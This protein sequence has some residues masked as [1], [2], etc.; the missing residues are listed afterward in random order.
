MGAQV[1]LR[2]R[3]FRLGRDERAEREDRDRAPGEIIEIDEDMRLVDRFRAGERL[4]FEQLVRKYQEPIY[5]LLL[6]H[7]RD[8]DEA[9]ELTQRAFIK[10][11]GGLAGFRGQAQFR[12]WLYRIAVNL[13]LNHLRDN[14]RF[15]R[16]VPLEERPSNDRPAVEQLA[17]HEQSQRL[18]R[19]VAR[20]P[21]KQRLTLELR[22]YDDLSFREVAEILGTSE[23]AAKV[24]Y[25]YAV[26][27]LKEWLGDD[28][29]LP[30]AEEKES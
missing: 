9:T 11:F 27:R 18:R 25:H 23:G 15:A 1:A 30:D 24:N 2:G 7:V 19:A 16:D 3:I 29:E 4:A 12:S 22:V 26:K 13:A 28:T 14:A 5:Y 20:L 8:P 6:R 17:Q 21:P 10:A